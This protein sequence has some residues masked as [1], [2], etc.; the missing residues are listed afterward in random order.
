M[1]VAFFR[2]D[3]LLSHEF[4]RKPMYSIYLNTISVI[5]E[6]HLKDTFQL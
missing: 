4:E 2:N 1:R 3:G 5:E 6:C